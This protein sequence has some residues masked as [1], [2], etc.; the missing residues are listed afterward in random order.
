MDSGQEAGKQ[1]LTLL[2]R[3]KEAQESLDTV[4]EE[5]NQSVTYLNLYLDT[6][7]G[8]LLSALF[9]TPRARFF[10][11]LG[12]EDKSIQDSVE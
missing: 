10:S 5:Y 6:F 7:P 4:M 1:A 2:H 8:S 12:D 11:G 9:G 3:A